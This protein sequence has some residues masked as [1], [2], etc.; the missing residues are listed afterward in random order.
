MVNYIM[1]LAKKSTTLEFPS[2]VCP[3][4]GV[5][6]LF[7]GGGCGAMLRKHGLVAY[8]IIDAYMIDIYS[9]LLDKEFKGED[10]LFFLGRREGRGDL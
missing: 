3:T 2:G 10:M 1:L 6:G 4:F 8:N 7:S 5:G 9:R